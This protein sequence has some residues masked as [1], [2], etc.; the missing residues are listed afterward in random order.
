MLLIFCYGVLLIDCYGVLLIDCYG[1]L[2]IDCYGVLL[3]DCYGVWFFVYFTFVVL[4]LVLLRVVS[5]SGV[6]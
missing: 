6:D 5:I 2:L 3:I 1:V 4:M